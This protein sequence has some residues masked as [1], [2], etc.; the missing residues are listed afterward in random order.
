MKILFDQGTPVPL[1]RHLTGHTVTTAYEAGWS[2]LSNGDLL[3]AA[4]KAEYQILVTTDQN[5]RYQQNLQERRIAIVVLRSTSWPRIRLRID[6][7]RKEI[8]A[9][10]V[11]GY[12]E[13]AI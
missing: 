5:L 12:V 10:R 9:S 13:I 7:V 6:A 1:R 8:D 2:A 4:E 11:G 3:V